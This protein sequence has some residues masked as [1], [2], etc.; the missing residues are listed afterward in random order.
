MRACPFCESTNV[1]KTRLRRIRCEECTAEAPTDVW[2]GRAPNI[3][4]ELIPYV[5]GL[6]IVKNPH[7]TNALKQLKK[8]I[9]VMT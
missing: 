2:E 6:T 8:E 4:V 1:T 5:M 3:P 9:E 7:A